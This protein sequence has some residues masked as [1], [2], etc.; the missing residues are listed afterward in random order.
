MFIVPHHPSRLTTVSS[1]KVEVM[2]VMEMMMIEAPKI[3]SPSWRSWVDALKPSQPPFHI[4]Q[5]Q[6]SLM[7]RHSQQLWWVWTPG[8]S[9][10]SE[11]LQLTW[12]AL[13]NPAGPQ[14]NGGQKR[15]VSIAQAT[16][17][18]FWQPPFLKEKP[19][20]SF[21]ELYIYT[22]FLLSDHNDHIFDQ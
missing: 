6:N 16:Q 3:I 9:M 13:G 2:V 10:N 18:L 5:F 22:L 4:L 19:W 1:M 21:N 12:L 20:L 8:L 7:G 14:R 11:P 15:L 17:G